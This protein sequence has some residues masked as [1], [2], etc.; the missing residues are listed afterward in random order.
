MPL[1]KKVLSGILE[2]TF[3]TTKSTAGDAFICR[4]ATSPT[5]P[6]ICGNVWSFQRSLTLTIIIT[7]Q[8]SDVNARKWL[9]MTSSTCTYFFNVSN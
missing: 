3:E 9:F 4:L 8:Q 7:L 6:Q 1:T 2:R 5:A